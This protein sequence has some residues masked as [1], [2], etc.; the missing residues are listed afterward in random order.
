[1][2]QIN[3]GGISPMRAPAKLLDRQPIGF[4]IKEHIGC[5]A[6]LPRPEPKQNRHILFYFMAVIL[7]A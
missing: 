2:C 7:S 5:M 1:M 3:Y 4:I 6:C